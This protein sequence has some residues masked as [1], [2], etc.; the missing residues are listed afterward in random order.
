MWRA[1]LLVTM[2][3][4]SGCGTVGSVQNASAAL[5][6]RFLLKESCVQ[7]S[8]ALIDALIE[9]GFRIDLR[10]VSQGCAA[11]LIASHPP[12]LFSW[13]EIV[14]LR[15]GQV[16]DG[17]ELSVRTER[18]LATNITARGDWGDLIFE[19]TVRNL[20]NER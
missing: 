18:V 2:L 7:V 4:A 17:L 14:R 3:A 6:R 20:L 10:N 9:L 19:T 1:L 13:G 8:T 15:L 12:T 16:P 5:D 11:Q